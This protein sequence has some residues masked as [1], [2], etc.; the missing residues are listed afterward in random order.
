[1][2]DSYS[3]SMNVFFNVDPEEQIELEVGYNDSDGV[4]AAAYA[5]GDDFIQVISD[6]CDQ[7]EENVA[8]AADEKADVDEIDALQTRIKELEAENADL[9]KQLG[10]IKIQNPPQEPHMTNAIKEMKDNAYK[11]TADKVAAHD[12]NAYLDQVFGDS[13]SGIMGHLKDVL[14]DDRYSKFMRRFS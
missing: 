8:T 3:C 11:L 14:N 9:L 5:A 2:T 6:V 13:Y 4:T 10:C 7:L 12:F 1:M